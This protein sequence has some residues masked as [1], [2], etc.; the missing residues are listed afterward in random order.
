MN[1]ETHD[2]IKALAK[3]E[4]NRMKIKRLIK[5]DDKLLSLVNNCIDKM[6]ICE[7]SD[8]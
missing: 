4:R 1:C 8:R 3:V 7:K 6:V 5:E 2:L